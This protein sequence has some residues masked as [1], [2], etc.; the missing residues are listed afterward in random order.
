MMLQPRGY[1]N[2]TSPPGA[3]TPATFKHGKRTLDHIWVSS[4]LAPLIT[5]YGYLPFDFGFTSDHRGMFV[6]IQRGNE[7]IAR[8]PPKKRWK[9]KSKNP[10]SVEKYLKIV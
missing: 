2:I 1:V 6:D 9:L 10:Q 8:L 7:E 3:N 4:A 5:R